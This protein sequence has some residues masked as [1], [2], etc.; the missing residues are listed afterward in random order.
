[1]D[2]GYPENRAVEQV[3]SFLNLPD[4]HEPKE[5][6]AEDLQPAKIQGCALD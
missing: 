6:F 1:L 3:C 2:W 4:I 5:A